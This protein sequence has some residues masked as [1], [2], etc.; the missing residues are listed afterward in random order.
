[1]GSGIAQVAAQ[2]GYQVVLV[3]LSEAFVQ[4]GVGKIEKSLSRSVEKGKLSSDEKEAVLRRIHASTRIEDLKPSELVVEA[5]C[6]AQ[7]IQV[8]DAEVEAQ[9][10][11]DAA[12]VSR[13]ADELLGEVRSEGAFERL[14]EDMRLGRAVQF[15]VD[16]A[17][18]ISAD[19]A[20]ARERLWTPKEDRPAADAKLWT[21]GDAT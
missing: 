15:L 6:V 14:R 16:G 12:K 17:V 1:M 5:V 13:D 11:E 8:T 7:D 3:D 4:A 19:Q 9:V 10:R 18:P 20:E 21:P 2:A